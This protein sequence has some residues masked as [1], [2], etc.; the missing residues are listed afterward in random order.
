MSSQLLRS[1]ATFSPLQGRVTV[2][3][4][5]MAM[6]SHGA[7]AVARRRLGLSSSSSSGGS[8]SN[9]LHRVSQHAQSGREIA[10]CFSL[11]SWFCGSSPVVREAPRIETGT[12]YWNTTDQVLD[13]EGTIRSS[14]T[15][16]DA[17]R[18]KEVLHLA[19]IRGGVDRVLM[20]K[21]QK[22][23]AALKATQN[24]Q[25]A[26]ESDS[27]AELESALR[28]AVRLGVDA[29]SMEEARRKVAYLTA[30]QT[31][32][33]ASAGADSMALQAALDRACLLPN[34]SDT[35]IQHGRSRLSEIQIE[36]YQ[37]EGGHSGHG[38]LSE[39]NLS[40]HR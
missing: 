6:G 1:L 37:S 17:P 31:L 15:A 9:A 2:A 21:G 25:V 34:V 12:D 39:S 27:I 38:Y 30:Q 10:P 8:T 23:L 22:L 24:L 33:A 4:I 18:L 36:A 7:H 32:L 5:P 14:I 20:S 19:E 28:E 16:A 35:L 26:L 40:L 13:V 11:T 3:M 29:A